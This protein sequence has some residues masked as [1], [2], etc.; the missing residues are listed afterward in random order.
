MREERGVFWISSA[1]ETVL[2]SFFSKLSCQSTAPRPHDCSQYTALAWLCAHSSSA[3]PRLAFS[4]KH[5]CRASRVARRL[6]AAMC[7][8]RRAEE[9]MAVFSKYAIKAPES[10]AELTEPQEFNLMFP[11]PIGP[12]GMLHGYLRPETAQGTC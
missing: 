11:T 6:V 10:G 4:V 1:E 8:R 2:S 3:R 5:T 7:C 9:L 12:T